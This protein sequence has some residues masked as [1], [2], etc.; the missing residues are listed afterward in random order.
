M[1]PTAD[2]PEPIRL[3]QNCLTP[4]HFSSLIP[5]FEALDFRA[6]PRPECREFQIF[7][8]VYEN[9]LHRGAGILGAVSSRFEAKTLLDGHDVRRWIQGHPGKDVYFVNPWP[10][11]I[12]ANFNV[13]E[14]GAIIH[15]VPEF[16]SYSQRILDKAGIPLHFESVGRQHQ[17][18]FGMSSY[19]FG[20]PRFWE[21]FV[22]ELVIPVIHL[23]RSELGSELH[24]FLYQPVDYYGIAHH[25]PGGLPFL[26]ERA[27]SLYIQAEFARSALYYPRTRQQVL[28]CCVFPFERD[29]VR[30]FGDQVDAWDTEGCYDAQAMAYFHNAAHLS[31]HGWLAYMKLHP[32]GF[33]HGNP[34]PHLPWFRQVKSDRR[35]VQEEAL[36]VL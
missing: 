12:Y 33:D 32:V 8:H 17:G 35:A 24:D 26:L 30:Q 16:V 36:T 3:L 27:T 21:K 2:E 7:E 29:L 28:D 25:R 1:N 10:Q 19:W 18:N 23:S 5:G 4:D 31:A 9:G 14:R 34:R 11:W 20:S 13:N 15:G 6:N 22:S